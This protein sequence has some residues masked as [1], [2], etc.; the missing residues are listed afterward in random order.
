MLCFKSFLRCDVAIKRHDSIFPEMS[1]P[2]L[3][4]VMAYTGTWSGQ[5]IIVRRAQ[6]RGNI[7]LSF[8]VSIF[9]S[10]P[11]QMKMYAC[12]RYMYVNALSL[13][14]FF[15][16]LILLCERLYSALIFIIAIFLGSLSIERNYFF[17]L[18]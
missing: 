6:H 3:R 13:L 9:S 15:F 12:S 17:F 10:S 1:D 2:G 11:R 14:F 4:S 16:C 7:I 8:L 18:L 5:N